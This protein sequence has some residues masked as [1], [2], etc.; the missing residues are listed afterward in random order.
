M[1][2]MGSLLVGAGILLTG[3]LA[4]LFRHPRAPRWTR[5]ELVAMLAVVPVTGVLGF[6]LGYMA[7][8]AYRVLNGAAGLYELAAPAALAIAAPLWSFSVRGRLR[9][10]GAATS[11]AG[12]TLTVAGTAGSQLPGRS[13]PTSGTA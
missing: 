9:A 10:Y 13:S 8:G 1:L 12:P 4:L 7:L 3:L 11:P 2:A 5:P 6:G